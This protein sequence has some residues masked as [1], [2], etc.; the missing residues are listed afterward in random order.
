MAYHDEVDLD[1]LGRSGM[2]ELLY[3]GAM[4]QSKETLAEEAMGRKERSESS[5]TES[6]D[7][8]RSTFVA[9]FK[10]TRVNQREER[11][12]SR[13]QRLKSDMISQDFPYQEIQRSS[14]ASEP[15]D[16]F[17]KAEHPLPFMEF[18]YEFVC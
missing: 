9:T 5:M 1:E 17:S 12:Q 14:N 8:Q 15:I 4:S 7:S 3:G 10:A 6:C 18:V 13:Y 11:R 16:F 2:L